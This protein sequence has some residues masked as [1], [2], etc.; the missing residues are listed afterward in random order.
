MS[1]DLKSYGSQTPD[2]AMRLL[3]KG[4]HLGAEP[5]VLADQRRHLHA[6]NQTTVL[7]RASLSRVIRTGRQVSRI[8][9]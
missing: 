9:N 8:H 3:L 4:L 5:L 2:S 7:F 1:D 6:R